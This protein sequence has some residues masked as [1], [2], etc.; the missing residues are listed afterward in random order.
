MI[1]AQVI[2]AVI[3]V[4]LNRGAGA[5]APGGAATP[6]DPRLRMRG[7]VGESEPARNPPAAPAV[8]HEFS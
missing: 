8:N 2:E 4:R 1:V 6:N 3:A 5:S 7:I